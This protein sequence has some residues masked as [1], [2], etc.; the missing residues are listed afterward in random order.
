MPVKENTRCKAQRCEM[1]KDP[2]NF[3]LSDLLDCGPVAFSQGPQELG[4]I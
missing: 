3:L 4:H 2:E 1:A